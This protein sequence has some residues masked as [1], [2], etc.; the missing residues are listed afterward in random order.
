LAS[1][2]HQLGQL[3]PVLVEH[4]GDVLGPILMARQHVGK[5]AQRARIDLVGLGQHVL[6][7]CDQLG[8]STRLIGNALIARAQ[9]DIEMLLAHVDSGVGPLIAIAYPT[10]RMHVHD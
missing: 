10:L 2:C 9:T 1:A 4:R 6:E 7:L 8:L 5:I 3:L